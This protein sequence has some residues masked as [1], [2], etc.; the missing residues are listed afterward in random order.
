[1]GFNRFDYMWHIGLA[2][3]GASEGVEAGVAGRSLV[4]IGLGLGAAV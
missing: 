2:E 3:V 4:R 1:M